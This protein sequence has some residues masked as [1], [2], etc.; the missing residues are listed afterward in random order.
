MAKPEKVAAVAELTKMFEGASGIFVTDFQ[1]MNVAE[2]SN[3]RKSLRQNKTKF[4]VAKNT[5]FRIAAKNANVS[6]IDD[7]LKGTTGVAFTSADAAPAAKVLNDAFKEKER[8][9]VKVFVV[10]KQSF[11]SAEIGRLA[12]LPSREILLSQLVAAVEAPLAQLASTIEGLFQELI[13]SVDALAEK[14]KGE[15]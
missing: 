2:V 15:S 4:V 9:R 14:K 12:D 7:F 10:D 5:L 11:K 1:G 3:L 8:P 6:G 13:R